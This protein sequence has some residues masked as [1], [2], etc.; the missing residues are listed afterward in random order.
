MLAI[1]FPLEQ[2]PSENAATELRRIHRETPRVMP[3]LLGDA[4][5]F[6]AEWAETVDAFEDP[7]AILAE[8]EFVDADAWFAARIPHLA[9]S[10]ARM[11]N[12]L[13]RFN[14]GWRFLILPFDLALLP[15]RL[16]RWA[17]TRERPEFF[18]RSPF[19]IGPLGANDDPPRTVDILRSQLS[20]LE[21]SGDGGDEELREMREVIEAIEADGADLRFFPDPVDYIT[22]RHGPTLAA[23]LIEADAPWKTAAWL[24]HGT[25]ALAAPKPVLVAHCRWLWET[26][27]ARIITASTDHIGFE[28]ERPV[29][30]QAEA[31]EILNRFFALCADEVNAE[32][33]GTDGSSLIGAS[34]WWVWWD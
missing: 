4:D 13:V 20:E 21:A 12:A 31:E 24:Q 2:I 29:G 16:V 7:A 33:R 3:V 6:A 1:P 34:R 30:T 27:G 8:A 26:H 17:M 23:A 10:E 15:A 5:V 9:R 22:P 28:V 18:S 14:K 32:H 25:Y 19:D 11:E